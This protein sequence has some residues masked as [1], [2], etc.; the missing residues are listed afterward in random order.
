MIWGW[1]QRDRLIGVMVDF[2]GD[3]VLQQE[4]STLYLFS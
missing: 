4:I 2:N 3:L 1:G